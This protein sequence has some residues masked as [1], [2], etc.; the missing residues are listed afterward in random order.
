[1]N[2]KIVLGIDLGTTYSCVAYVNAAGRPEV[3]KNAEGENTTPSVVYFD[4]SSNRVDVGQ[5]A[6]EQAPVDPTEVASFIKRNIGDD[7]FRF[8]CKKGRMRPEEVS[9][10]ILKKLVKD[11]SK[12]LGKEVK[13]V[14]ITCPAYFFVKEREATKKAGEIA[15]LNVIQLLNEPTAA[16]IAYGMLNG[17]E[18]K[19]ILVYDLGGGTFDVTVIR[20]TEGAIKVVATGGDPKLGGKDWDDCLVRIV[21]DRIREETGREDL[22]DSPETEQE[23]RLMAEK[24]KKSLTQSERATGKFEH[25]GETFRPQVTRSE[26]EAAT[27]TLLDRTLAFTDDVLAKA[28]DKG[29]LGFDEL[30]LVGGSTRMPQVMRALSE[31]YGIKPQFHDPDEAVAKGAAILGANS[32]LRAALEEKVRELTNDADFS[33]DVEGGGNNRAL[34]QAKQEMRDEGYSLEA[35]QSAMTDIVNVSSKTFGT[36]CIPLEYYKKGKRENRLFNLIYRNSPLPAEAVFPC[37]TIDDNQSAVDF[38]VLEN[39]ADRPTT[40]EDSE[41]VGAVG[42]DPEIGTSLWKDSLSIPSGLPAGEKLE[43][44]FKMDKEGMLDVTCQHV[45]TGRFIHTTIRTGETL[46]KAEEAEIRQRQAELV[47]E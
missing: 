5:I 44:V 46:S 11:A 27:K 42:V 41:R 2:D 14:V 22:S 45:A 35:L 39:E 9:A 24:M 20:I 10:F 19:T 31:K 17:G 23:L 4:P 43:V 36:L 1:M 33:L 28:K 30:L 7:G 3:L 6:K 26:F 21:L 40:E 18:D 15:G 34:E 25:E 16:A 12:E 13:D 32:V 37:E 47:V 38:E 8:C 29:V